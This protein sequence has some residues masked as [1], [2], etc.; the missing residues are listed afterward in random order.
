MAAAR[1]VAE[2]QKQ[3]SRAEDADRQ[4]DILK[5]LA[6]AGIFSASSP[7]ASYADYRKSLR[8]VG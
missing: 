7:Y 1:E 2:L 8:H 6:K 3:L 5:A 4:L